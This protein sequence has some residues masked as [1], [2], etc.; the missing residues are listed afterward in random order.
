MMS[1]GDG[2]KGDRREGEGGKATGIQDSRE[3]GW[4]CDMLMGKREMDN[5]LPGDM[6]AG[7]NATEGIQ[8][9]SYSEVVIQGVRRRARVFEGDLTVRKT[10][11][12]MQGGC[13]M[14]NRGHG[15]RNCRTMA[16]NMIVQQLRWEEEVG[17]VGMFCWKG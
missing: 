7:Q 10:E 16:I 11:S 2:S 1:E 5:L 8:R 6:T 4:K 13:V 14:G 17:F 9:K 12:A 3:T 15:Y